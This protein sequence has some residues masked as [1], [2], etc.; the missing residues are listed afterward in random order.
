MRLELRASLAPSIA[1]VLLAIFPAFVVAIAPVA[2]KVICAAII[3]A[4]I[5]LAVALGKRRLVVDERG[6]TAKGAFGLTRLEW[7]E[8]DHYTYWSMDHTMA[9][10]AGGQGALAAVII[11]GIVAA[12][13][14]LGKGKQGNRR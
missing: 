10:A 2:G 8:V 11:I 3:V 1:L 14:A 5:A 4:L 7:D 6:M 12:V 13:R 9:Y